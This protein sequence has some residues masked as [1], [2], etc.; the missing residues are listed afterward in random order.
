VTVRAGFRGHRSENRR[1]PRPPPHKNQSG[2]PSDRRIPFLARKARCETGRVGDPREGPRFRRNRLTPAVAASMSRQT[3]RVAS[4]GKP[5]A[6]GGESPFSG[7]QQR[8]Q[9]CSAVRG[10][11]RG[12]IPAG[13]HHRVEQSAPF[14]STTSQRRVLVLPESVN[15]PTTDQPRP[16]LRPSIEAQKSSIESYEIPLQSLALPHI[17]SGVLQPSRQPLRAGRKSV[18][19]TNPEGPPSETHLKIH[20]AKPA[21]NH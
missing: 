8:G 21:T 13:S 19:Q 1:S 4:V 2:G 17:I 15:Q 3:V 5:I 9:R 20:R 11:W 16:Q 12:C 10:C 14:L 7:T 6:L 18:T